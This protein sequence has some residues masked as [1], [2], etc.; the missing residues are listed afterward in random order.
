MIHKRFR[1]QKSEVRNQAI[2]LY[3]SRITVPKINQ[4][5]FLYGSR[6][7]VFKCYLLDFGV[8]NNVPQ[9][10]LFFLREPYN[11]FYEPERLFMH[12]TDSS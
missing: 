1:S 10:K 9:I 3:G 2:F 8:F 5:I 7:T 11:R 6:I 12:L 4:A